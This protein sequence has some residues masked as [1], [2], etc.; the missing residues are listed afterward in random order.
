MV[1]KSPSW[2]DKRLWL[3]IQVKPSQRAKFVAALIQRN[4]LA[5]EIM[6]NQYPGYGLTG[7]IR[8]DCYT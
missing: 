8:L 4:G 2:V 1:F 6:A 3:T 5:Y 7:G